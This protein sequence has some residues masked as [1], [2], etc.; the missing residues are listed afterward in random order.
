MDGLVNKR[1]RR[2]IAATGEVFGAGDLIGEH[3]GDEVLGVHAL[4]LWRHA[5]AAAIA[6]NSQ[7]PRRIPA[8]AHL[9]HRRVEQRLNEHIAH[10]G[11]LQVAEHLVER[12]TVYRAKRDDDAVF[13]CRRLQFKIERLTETLAQSET[14]A[15]IDATSEGRVY[16]DV[17]V[18]HFVEETLHDYRVA[19]R[20]GTQCR[21][22]CMQVFHHLRRCRRW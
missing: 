14:P 2:H 3:V 13:V 19:G 1:V 5:L 18:P 8:P 20:H 10:R 22:T 7:R 21:H 4:E 12:K 6:L 16:D 9:K 17:H 15:A 11:G